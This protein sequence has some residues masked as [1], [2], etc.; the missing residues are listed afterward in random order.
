LLLDAIFEA[1]L[2]ILLLVLAIGGRI[3]MAAPANRPAIVLIAVLLLMIAAVLLLLI[4]LAS[5]KLL[6]LVA[7]AN[8]SAAFVIAFWLI[9]T[10]RNFSS[11][12]HLVVSAT[13]A[14]LI[15]VAIVEL[16]ST[17]KAE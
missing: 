16:L 10:W 4:P 15:V 7:L 17:L 11:T 13:T 14:G 12:G 2:G 8:V 3:V 5:S 1:A 6:S 9:A